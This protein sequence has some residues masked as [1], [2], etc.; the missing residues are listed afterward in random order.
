MYLSTALTG[1]I[2]RYDITTGAVRDLV[3]QMHNSTP[4][5]MATNTAGTLIVTA[6][7]DPVVVFVHATKSDHRERLVPQ[8]SDASVTIA[9]FHKGR[10]AVF[11]L[12]FKNGTLAMY[13]A[14]KLLRAT[15]A[16]DQSYRQTEETCW[17]RR[18]HRTTLK[19]VIDPEW[20]FTVGHTRTS[21]DVM[22]PFASITGAEFLSG[23]NSRAVT[24]GTDGRC[25]LVDFEQGG[26]I[27]NTWHA[28]A[29][30][31]CLAITAG[32]SRDAEGATNRSYQTSLDT[33]ALATEDGRVV[34]YSDAGT[35]L[36]ETR[37]DTPSD[38]LSLE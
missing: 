33:I 27:L 29:A 3:P 25:R 24:V 5:I 12:G 17:F 23:H 26:Q 7:K 15:A 16:S 30:I 20:S 34:F 28:H 14:T 37:L 18:L 32:S 21:Q 35:K 19:G 8:A 11:L 10:P 1:N 36:Y 22:S 38:I 4:T 9:A 6:S 2:Q 31:Q 13:D